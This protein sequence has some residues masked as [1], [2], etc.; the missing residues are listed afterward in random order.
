MRTLAILALSLLLVACLQQE[1]DG[2]RVEK[3]WIAEIPP[4]LTVTAALMT[5]HNDSDEPT[6]LI[7]ATSP[8]TDSIEIHRSIIVDE[9]AKM[10]QQKAVEI[11][12]HGSVEFSNE[13]GYHLMLYGSK[14]IKAGR[15]I[16]ITLQ[17]RDGSA[18]TVNYEVVDRRK[19]L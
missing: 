11:P 2:I 17:F 10:E 16:P 14:E 13:T 12:P 1:T 19:L 5:L 8:S 3:A 7:G 6:Y 4:M 18:L 9:L 15:R